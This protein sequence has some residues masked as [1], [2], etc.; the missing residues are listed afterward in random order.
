M[1]KLNIDNRKFNL[2]IE[3]AYQLFLPGDVPNSYG[4]IYNPA[5]IKYN[6]RNIFLPRVEEF[7][8]IQRGINNKWY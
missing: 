4:G 2:P 8:E 3:N 6:N 7:T 1:K 5:Y